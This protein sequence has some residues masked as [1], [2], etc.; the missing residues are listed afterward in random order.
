MRREIIHFLKPNHGARIPAITIRIGM[1]RAEEQTLDEVGLTYTRP[2]PIEADALV[3][4]G[5][6]RTFG[7]IPG[8]CG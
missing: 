2:E 7:G 4:T 3:D 1:S 6:L 5:A 8:S